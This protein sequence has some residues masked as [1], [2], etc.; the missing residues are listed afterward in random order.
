MIKNFISD[1][2]RA[3]NW[4]RFKEKW[5]VDFFTSFITFWAFFSSCGDLH[6]TGRLTIHHCIVFL[7]LYL[8]MYFALFSGQIHS[9][10]PEKMMYLCPMDIHQ[11]RTYIYSSYYF[12]VIL[13]MVILVMGIMI[14]FPFS[15]CD[16]VSI[17]EILLNGLIIS[18]FI[19]S[20]KNTRTEMEIVEVQKG[21]LVGVA[22]ISN[23]IQVGI[24]MDHKPDIV[25]KTVLFVVLLFVQL[26]LSIRYYKWVKEELRA[27]VN[28]EEKQG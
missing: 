11:R 28:Y 12:R 2:M 14:L 8:P 18:G 4:E 20:G 25:P 6:A 24:I 9:V 16:G 1:Y 21:I 22:I 13:H 19:P 3:Y 15:Y 5:E 23:V 10:K 7:A 17:A 27:A 26:P